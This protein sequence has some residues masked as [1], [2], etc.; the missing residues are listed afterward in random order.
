MAEE[1]PLASNPASPK[2]QLEAHS[3]SEIQISTNAKI[4][5]TKLNISISN[6]TSNNPLKNW[7]ENLD[8][9]I[10]SDIFKY[11]N[12]NSKFER[13]ITFYIKSTNFDYTAKNKQ[14]T[15]SKS[16]DVLHLIQ[17]WC[18]MLAEFEKLLSVDQGVSDSQ[19]SEADQQST[20]S[21]SFE[22]SDVN[23]GIL[24]N[25]LHTFLNKLKS[26]NVGVIL[27]LIIQFHA[28]KYDLTDT[29]LEKCLESSFLPYLTSSTRTAFFNNLLNNFV[30]HP[31]ILL[32]LSTT[33]AM[34]CVESEGLR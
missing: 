31:Y 5:A 8:L 18:L 16:N 9:S 24:Y 19:K 34:N 29:I 13:I 20:E 14:A 2:P 15:S 25:A 32:F 1:Q 21:S 22:D 4:L 23:E 33:L 3:S 17:S 7:E 6:L 30:S 11:C 10:Q 26:C 28:S 27:A 12:G